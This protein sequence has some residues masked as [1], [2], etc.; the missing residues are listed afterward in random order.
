MKHSLRLF[1]VATF[2]LLIAAP[3]VVAQS[4]PITPEVSVLPVAEPLDVGGTVLRPGT[5]LIKVIQ[6]ADSR[7]KVQVLSRD[8]SKVFATLLTVPHEL[9][10]NEEIPATTFV[11]YPPTENHPRALRTWFAANPPGDHGHDIVYPEGR[12][13]Q[14]ALA[15]KTNVVSYPAS[16]ETATIDTSTLSVQT[17]QST[18]EVYTPPPAPVITETTTNTVATTDTPMTSASET[19]TETPAEMPNT[20][21]SIPTLALLGVLAI[22][23][24]L[25]LRLRG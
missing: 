2:A 13:R 17:P 16:T 12:A 23:G 6:S 3:V 9:E 14:L 20:A 21:S 1:A 4:M 22:A 11:F 25:A 18:V 7:N 15:A 5:Y 19:Q 8:G 24:A 10:P